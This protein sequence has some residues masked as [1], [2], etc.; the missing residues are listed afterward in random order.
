MLPLLVGIAPLQL[1]PQQ[2]QVF[3]VLTKVPQN[4][5][6][7]GSIEVCLYNESLDRMQGISV[8]LEPNTPA[9]QINKGLKAHTHNFFACTGRDTRVQSLPTRQTAEHNANSTACLFT[10]KPVRS[11]LVKLGKRESREG[12]PFQCIGRIVR[13]LLL[14]KQYH[15]LSWHT[16]NV[17][18]IFKHL[19]NLH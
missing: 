10:I 11:S 12:N 4:H 14:T 8:Y 1:G 19:L 16:A 7:D 6:T 9:S 5:V 18:T 2:C 13:R 15:N 17:E 3:S